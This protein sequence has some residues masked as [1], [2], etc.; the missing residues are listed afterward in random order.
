MV[1]TENGLR[2]DLDD[3]KSL[4]ERVEHEYKH[5][6]MEPCIYIK[7]GDKPEIIQYCGYAECFPITYTNTVK[8][9]KR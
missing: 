6:S 9:E 1:Y 5:G 7:G 3:L 2:L 8:T 4:V